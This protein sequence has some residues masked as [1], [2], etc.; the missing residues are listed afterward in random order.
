MD[1]MIL[2]KLLG[3]EEGI[4]GSYAEPWKDDQD[5]CG[6]TPRGA[7]IHLDLPV[8]GGFVCPLPKHACVY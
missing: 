1:V 4:I 5:D 3:P 2:Y 6:V 8:F 7:K